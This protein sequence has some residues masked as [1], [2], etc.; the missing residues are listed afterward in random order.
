MTLS[1]YDQSQVLYL[2]LLSR[3]EAAGPIMTCWMHFNVALMR[4]QLALLSN[5]K[6]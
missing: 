4:L 2:Y 5:S 6:R 1:L 3:R